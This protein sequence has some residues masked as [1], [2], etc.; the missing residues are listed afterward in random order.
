MGL[1]TDQTRPPALA[2][3]A[4]AAR[5]CGATRPLDTVIPAPVT[6]RHRF[7]RP[8]S[9]HASGEFRSA[10]LEVAARRFNCRIGRVPAF[11]GIAAGASGVGGRILAEESPT[12]IESKRVNS[13]QYFDPVQSG[14]LAA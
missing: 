12:P 2:G 14:M 9:V 3:A 11:A 10:D 13:A 5:P 6:A 1:Q 4:A 8:G 7:L